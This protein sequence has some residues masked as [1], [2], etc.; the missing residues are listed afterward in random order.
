MTKDNTRKVV[1]IGLAAF[2]V[3][4]AMWFFSGKPAKDNEGSAKNELIRSNVKPM[5]QADSLSTAVANEFAIGSPANEA[6]T[7]ESRE[8]EQ[9]I[10]PNTVGI[11]ILRAVLDKSMKDVSAAY[12][13]HCVLSSPDASASVISFL[14]GK[15]TSGVVSIDAL[16]QSAT[17]ALAKQ[18]TGMELMHQ[19]QKEKDQDK[20]LAAARLQVAA[21]REFVREDAFLTVE[22]STDRAYPPVRSFQKGLPDWVIY[23]EKA[24][25]LAILHLADEP[26]LREFTR[27]GID[28]ATIFTYADRQGKEVYVDPRRGQVYAHRSIMPPSAHRNEGTGT[29]SVEATRVRIAK[30]WEEFLLNGIDFAQFSVEDLRDLS[31]GR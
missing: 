9:W 12:V 26:S 30:Q 18:K 7:N 19:A 10:A 15:G 24:Y 11:D 23:R 20:M 17:N 31:K 21:D 29:A 6:I 27:Q 2:I 8:N 25:M 13:G 3:G 1:N 22:V 5:A 14:Y 4:L 28:G 16:A